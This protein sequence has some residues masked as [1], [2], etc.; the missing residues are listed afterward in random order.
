VGRLRSG[1]SA[2]RESEVAGEP[3][4][5]G[6]SS[7]QPG[8]GRLV[9]RRRGTRRAAIAGVTL[10]LAGG[11][12]AYGA[13]VAG[14]EPSPSINEV[15]AKVNKLQ[16]QADQIGTQYDQVTQ[17]LK[18]AQ[19]KLDSVKKRVG[20]A[21][22]AYLTARKELRQVAVASYMDS[23]QSSMAGLL[24]SANPETVLNSASLL[25]ELA[26]I[27]NAQANKFLS[28][29]QQVAAAQAQFNRTEAGIAEIQ[30]QLAAKKKNLNKLLSQSQAT[31]DSLNLQQQEAVATIGGGTCHASD[32]F[33]SGSPGLEAVKFAYGALCLPYEW[34]ATGPGAYDC[35]G[36]TQ[37]A[38]A[39]AG[40]SIPRDTYS[41]WAALPHVSKADLQAGDLVFFEGLGHVGIY[42]GGGMMID[43]PATGQV[44]TLH[45]LDEAWYAENYVGAARP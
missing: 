25:A 7:A 35:S 14:A 27:H 36:L 43:A 29:A 6:V 24:S 9:A 16:T 12:G 2:F 18:S 5:E 21:E 41:Q 15:Q 17:Q 1:G 44:V 42:V 45:A 23:A 37:A 22:S 39:A 40:V 13:S 4:T 8:A 34:G 33:G 38:W 10:L 31:L 28:A 26:N 19:A 30:S 20:K 32:P 3:A 11:L